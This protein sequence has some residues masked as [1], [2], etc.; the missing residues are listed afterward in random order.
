MM[1]ATGS[2]TEW[3]MNLQHGDQDAAAPLWARYFDRLAAVV[4]EKLRPIRHKAA[5]EDDV[6]ASAFCMFCQ[7]AQAGRFAELQGRDELWKVLVVIAKCKAISLLRHELAQV[8]GEGKVQGEAF[9]A[10]IVSREPSPQFATELLDETEHLLGILRLEDGSLSLIATRKL[11]GRRN[12]EIAAELGV[13]LRTVQ[14]K[15][16]RISI[17][18]AADAEK[19]DL[20]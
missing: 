13:T 7:R 5:D 16:E 19:R 12:Q 8:R 10:D 3:V 4:R 18:W 11:E 17:I 20:P 9:L 1:E 2:V 14:R 6:A 15:I